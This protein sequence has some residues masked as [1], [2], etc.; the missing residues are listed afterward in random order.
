MRKK[1]NPSRISLSNRMVS[2]LLALIMVVSMLPALPM[3]VLAAEI[4]IDESKLTVAQPKTYTTGTYTLK[5]VSITGSAGQS[6]IAISGN[7]TLIIEGTVVLN[8]G[9]ADY[10]GGKGA[11]AGIEVPAGSSLTLKGNGTLVA[12]GGNAANGGN[13]LATT[14]TLYEDG[15]YGT[16][17]MPGMGGGGAGAGIGSR[18]AN[19]SQHSGGASATAPGNITIADEKLLVQAT[20]G[21]GGSGGSGGDGGTCM[22]IDRF[23][24]WWG[25]PALGEQC[26]T[27]LTV[28]GGSGGSGGGGGGYPAA[29]IG[30][31]G[32]S[33]G[34]G[35]FGGS[36]GVD[37]NTIDGGVMVVAVF[38]EKVHFSAAGGGGGGGGQGFVNGG[39]GG[40]G[41]AFCDTLFY[42]TVNGGALAVGGLRIHSNNNHDV[43]LTKLTIHRY[44]G[45]L[46]WDIERDE[47]YTPVLTHRI[48]LLP[49]G[50]VHE[51]HEKNVE[52]GGCTCSGS[53]GESGQNGYDVSQRCKCGSLSNGYG[54]ISGGAG[55]LGGDGRNA[56]RKPASGSNGNTAGKKADG[57][58]VTLQAGTLRAVS[59]GGNAMDI[60]SGDGVGTANSGNLYIRGGALDEG[61]YPAPTNGTE[62][63]YPV[64][65]RPF[66][67]ID[68]FN[69][70]TNVLVSDNAWGVT[71]FIP[72]RSDGQLTVWLPNGEYTA[73][74]ANTDGSFAC[75]YPAFTVNGGRT[76]PIPDA[77]VRLDVS[78]GPITIN[79]ATIVQNENTVPYTSNVYLYNSSETANA[80]TFAQNAGVKRVTLQNA[81]ITTLNISSGCTVTLNSEGTQNTITTINNKASDTADVIFEGDVTSVLNVGTVD[82]V[83]TARESYWTGSYTYISEVAVGT[84]D[85]TPQ[86]RKNLTD[87]GFEY[88]LEY[89]LNAGA[90]G[91][92]IYIGYKTTTN[93]DEAIYELMTAERSDPMYIWQDVYYHE[94][95][96]YGGNGDL[97]QGAGGDWIKL[98]YA[99]KSD[100]IYGTNKK[101]ISHIEVFGDEDYQT[102][103][104]KRDPNVYPEWMVGLS[105]DIVLVDGGHAMELNR[106]AGGHYIYIGINRYF[107][108]I[109]YETTTRPDLLTHPVTSSS[110]LTDS[111]QS[112][113]RA[114]DITMN[115][116]GTVKI[117]SIQ[118]RRAESVFINPKTN[119][120]SGGFYYRATDRWGT[121]NLTVNS[122]RLVFDEYIKWNDAILCD[123]NYSVRVDSNGETEIWPYIYQTYYYDP[124]PS[125]AGSWQ[126][127]P[128]GFSGIAP[129]LAPNWNFY[130]Y[131]RLGNVT[132]NGGT[133]Q[134]GDGTGTLPDGKANGFSNEMSISVAPG[135][136]LL[137]N[138]V[139][140][141]TGKSE[142]EITGLP[143]NEH[144]SFIPDTI[145]GAMLGSYTGNMDVWTN[146]NGNFITYLPFFDT[147]EREI[148]F[149]ASNGEAYRYL[150]E[151][152][153]GDYTA[154]RQTLPAYN[155]PK[156]GHNLRIHPKYMVQGKTL[157]AHTEGEAVSITASMQDI[158]FADGAK[159]DLS[160][161]DGAMISSISGDGELTLTSGGHVIVVSKIAV[162]KFT[163]T[164]GS[165]S[166]REITGNV[167]ILGGSV[168]TDTPIV[169]AS[170]GTDAVYQAILPLWST[171]ITVDGKAYSMDNAQ[172]HGDGKTYIYVPANARFVKAG[173]EYFMLTF[174]EQ[175][176][177]MQVCQRITGDGHIDLSLGSTEILTNGEYIFNGQYYINENGENYTV[178]GESDINTLTVAD[179][180]PNLALDGVSLTGQTI[181]IADGVKA[182]LMLKGENSLVGADGMPA[183][184]VPA[185]AALTIEG[186]GV[187]NANGGVG[188]PAIGGGINEVNGTVTVK[189]G[190]LNLQGSDIHAI[191]AGSGAE[192][193][194]GSIIITGGS[195]K[196]G[197]LY[198]GD[199]LGTT[200]VNAQG[201]KLSRVVL[202]PDGTGRVIVDGV[203]YSVVTPNSDGR[204]YLYV[205]SREQT[206]SVGNKDYLVSPLNIAP[207]ENGTISLRLIDG[208]DLIPLK[209]GDMVVEGTKIRVISKADEG[210]GQISG[211]A[212]GD[213]V[214]TR[215]GDDLVLKATEGFGTFVAEEWTAGQTEDMTFSKEL[216]NSSSTAKLGVANEGHASVMFTASGKGITAEILV[217][218]KVAKTVKLSETVQTVNYDWMSDGNEAVELRFSGTGTVTLTSALLSEIADSAMIRA[219]FAKTVT[220][221][222]V[223]QQE[224]GEH[225]TGTVRVYDT[226]N[227]LALVDR[228][229][230][231][232]GI[233]V[234]A[235]TEIRV[236]FDDP[237]G[238][239]IFKG[240]AII[241][242]SEKS[243]LYALPSGPLDY[244]YTFAVTKD[245]TV[246][247]D[248]VWAEIHLA[249]G[250]VNFGEITYGDYAPEAKEIIIVDEGN[251]DATIE[252][253]SIGGANAD[254]FVLTTASPFSLQGNTVRP[255]A[256][257]TAGTHTAVVTV[258][259]NNGKT[260][261][262]EISITVNKKTV[263]TPVI[264][265]ATYNASEQRADIGD[266]DL[267]TVV[268][269]DGGTAKGSY[270]VVLKLKDATNYKWANTDDA[271]LTLQFTI[272]SAQN[273]WEI[274]PSIKD[275]TYGKDANA[276]VAE[277]K[278]GSFK[279]VYNGK[280]N[281]GSDYNSE[282][283]PT[284]AG[285][286]IAT[287]TV[288]GT[289]DYSGLTEQVSFTVEKAN[290][291]MSSAAW[292][293]T[294]AFDY[295]DKAH[296]V[297]VTGLPSG[298]TV[299]GY[300]GNTATAVGDYTAAVTFRYDANN[301][302]EPVLADLS[303]SIKNDWTPTEYTVNGEGWI[304]KDLVISPNSGYRVSL[305]NTVDGEWNESLT[306]SA[307]TADGSVTFYLKNETTGAISLAKTVNYKIDKTVSSGKVE[308]VERSGWEEFVSNITFGLFYKGEVTVKVT[309]NDILSGVAKI[310]YAA[311]SEAKSLN[312]VME[313][314]DWTEY[315]GSF[316]VTLEDA[317]KFVYF[318]RI[319]DNAGN[320][321]Y[322]STDGA[323]YD[324]TAPVIEGIENV[325]TYYTTQKVT[326]T[327][328][329]V[330]SITLNGETAGNEI[331][332]EGNKNTTYTIVV[333]DK[334]GNS[335]TV[336]VTMKPISDLSAP[337]DTLTRDNVNSGN[338]QAVDGVK[339][340]VA[341][342]DTTNATDAE[343]QALKDIADK[344]AELE[345]VIDDIKAE[346]ARITEELN[347]FNA[348]TVN[349]DDAPALEQ[350]AKNIKELIDG[351]NLTDAERTAL[352]EDAGKVA[353]IQKIVADTTAEN[354]R[355]SDAVDS[356][357]LATVTSEDKDYLEQL[358]AD[359]NKQLESTNLTEEEIS[360]LNGDKK[361]VEDLLT[362]IKGT[363]ELIDKLIGDV[364]GYSDDTVKSTD[365]DA[366]AQIIK[367]IDALLETENLTEDEKKALEDAK[368]KAEGLLETIDE[369]AKATKTENTEKVKDIT[370]ENVTPE[371]KADLEKA[372]ADLEQA[373]E[374]YGDNYTEDEKKA[375][376][377][378][379]KRIDDALEVIENVKVV[380]EQIN[381]LPD[382]ITKDDTDDVNAAKKAYDGLSDYEKTLI[383][384]E[385]KKKLE[386]A[387]KAAEAVNKPDSP[388][389]GDNSHMGLWFTLMLGSLLVM[390][391][392]LFGKKR[393][394]E[395]K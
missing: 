372:K 70:P 4:P 23:Y 358:L 316:G 154:V 165:L 83:N 327:E 64:I 233:Q 158:L 348:D 84:S 100:Y 126:H 153:M 193:T 189:G 32:A 278:F 206:V 111:K 123:P 230:A 210:Y 293:Y 279:V 265:G 199:S 330:A 283:A 370:A 346:I 148:V 378:E 14:T 380:E 371:D 178:T 53:G 183:I 72:G 121:S 255:K 343:K 202:K 301:Y 259:Y 387:V 107:P 29:G 170:N 45:I 145:T 355:I 144:L 379:I 229:P 173:G 312:E 321:T 168:K 20:G 49:A 143:E 108:G 315:N 209:S 179:G 19:G 137:A 385:T 217:N 305:T 138:A 120:P 281:D 54:G 5:D 192:T 340:V 311:S 2:A 369:A 197:D 110:K 82:N 365:K 117:G 89:E 226:S 13:G 389:T 139:D 318:V 22:V 364:D 188:A 231:K 392:L 207:T 40:G 92:H 122:G 254:S 134:I 237:E 289:E 203:D 187:L 71:R 274:A 171:D 375:V 381:A 157:Y 251:T 326:V 59:G 174:D 234:V 10:Y 213:Y 75:K 198:S 65:L 395:T 287:F 288:E 249:A 30:A 270:D 286:Y 307:E 163:F 141:N 87:N 263:E 200:P 55:G 97:N 3:S 357:D 273:A 275:W 37:K 282:A 38:S 88:I 266:T 325:K 162:P 256:G 353:D 393:K 109:I 102:A 383:D 246:M 205:V 58:T 35:G 227:G 103:V 131:N 25:V 245:T 291:D 104:N 390:F 60:G 268:K 31:G 161:A 17:Y 77:V 344:A 80:V 204:L 146:D 186:I 252:D 272:S 39:G 86:A 135:G 306:Y 359:I 149:T 175:T 269:N 366:I 222:I 247:P 172:P 12:N 232:A 27:D 342:V 337:I 354:K 335:T 303:W 140:T 216:N 106:K 332:L 90:G 194:E 208:E 388:Q 7:V 258:Q 46:I 304:N 18:G 333:T 224:D 294:T 78:A 211:P 9:D 308:F 296:K 219:E 271:E 73:A 160:A 373:L 44:D 260:A 324:T 95:P 190:T 98:Y 264:A 317:K 57:G 159:V 181:R 114:G 167:T 253:I 196:S 313:I 76:E 367:D 238:G 382:D 302:N 147:T 56:I 105:K 336:T 329:N 15:S 129:E 356:Y 360:E 36:G 99:K 79:S 243:G 85:N 63:V 128:M 241:T 124:F 215:M 285:N 96:C 166:T 69:A 115:S 277:A 67:Y 261:T 24:R 118:A 81:S 345:K 112:W 113:Q 267:Y 93:P 242:E 34:A 299:D 376:E 314:A 334:A 142:L 235:G 212:S 61:N 320:V 164:G 176:Q 8:G 1:K 16:A 240:F 169:G 195:I 62:A 125:Y 21:T 297:E 184:H 290:H 386:A 328:K 51:G 156:D 220:L 185:G 284:K 250:N 33:G 280:A 28:L 66:S 309:A 257:L 151:G 350:L 132:V 361:A 300:T 323:E 127:K 221:D 180:N 319:T 11:G 41:A 239:N 298:V 362:K 276:P 42:S 6:A 133:L 368:N 394:S 201:Q 68:D 191:G 384:P 47:F 182:T 262:S 116:L 341:A 338:K 155:N 228:D 347:K 150:I 351:D 310:E 225:A 244:S 48:D 26:Y 248:T 363:D 43:S 352:T 136:N 50:S 339:A 374:D 130:G 91:T 349:S 214:L 94:A 391:A 236:V 101:P 295:T 119:Q 218:G 377:D 177:T 52:N 223:Q 74:V 331:T 292:T 322:L 152:S